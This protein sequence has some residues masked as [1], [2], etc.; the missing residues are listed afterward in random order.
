MPTTSWSALTAPAT[1][2]NSITTSTTTS[3]ET[4]RTTHVYDAF[5]GAASALT[6]HVSDT[7]SAWT[8]GAASGSALVS[9]DSVAPTGSALNIF[10]PF[11]SADTENY[12]VRAVVRRTAEAVVLQTAGM[13]GRSAF[14][15]IEQASQVGNDTGYDVAIIVGSFIEGLVGAGNALVQ[16]QRLDTS[17]NTS[18]ATAFAQG[19]TRT[20]ELRMA[21]AAISVWVDN[22]QLLALTDT[23]TKSGR[24][25]GVQFERVDTS[26]ATA[27]QLLD[28]L[29]YSDVVS[30]VTSE[31]TSG[32]ASSVWTLR[33]PRA[34][35][36]N[37]L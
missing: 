17:L 25:V 5:G 9:S 31:T 14:T 15:S 18:K 24:T 27:L 20:F 7:G 29:A 21:N 28:F 8:S 23:P 35:T 6:A 32:S 26:D 16:L 1:A 4:S 22:A 10:Y 19:S 3:T 34:T 12:N 36:W 30:V 11:A 33:T 2:T 13:F 37:N